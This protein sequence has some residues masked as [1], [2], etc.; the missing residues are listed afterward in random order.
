M[1]CFVIIL[2][3]LLS[4]SQNQSELDSFAIN[5]PD[6]LTYSP[7]KLANHINYNFTKTDEKVRVLYVWITSQ[8]KYNEKI[9]DSLKNDDLVIYTLKTRSGICKNYS[10]LLTSLCLLM[11]I[12]AYSTLGY[13]KQRKIVETKNDHAWNIIKIDKKYYLFDP[14]W[15]A[16]TKLYNGNEFKYNYYKQNSAHF[17]KSH[18]PYDPV[19]Q[20]KYFPITHKE[21]FLNQ[22]SGNKKMDFK[23]SL[24]KYS[25]L[26]E[27]EKLHLMLKRAEE[28]KIDIPELDFLYKRLKYFVKSTVIK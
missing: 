1:K 27:K 6:S 19:M 16:G 26:N 5:I 17:I 18:M 25:K 11:N 14:T 8:I 7:L 2:F 23:H 12:E 3:P 21:F 22:P 9:I 13:T 4:F 28:N 20:L 10:A 24:E 15:D